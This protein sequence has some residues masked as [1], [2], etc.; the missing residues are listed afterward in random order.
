MV[1]KL[2]G[3]QQSVPVFGGFFGRR[4]VVTYLTLHEKANFG[5]Y[6]AEM[7]QIF[8]YVLNIIFLTWL[9]SKMNG[10]QSVGSLIIRVTFN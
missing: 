2:C 9:H 6:S 10:E 7:L 1:L 4:L 5:E 3:Q 8:F